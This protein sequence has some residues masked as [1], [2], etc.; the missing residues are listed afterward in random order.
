MA[1]MLDA[2]FCQEAGKRFVFGDTDCASTVDRWVRARLG[3]SPFDRY[4]RRHHDEA[5][6]RAWL[7]EPGSIA[8][9]TNRI[10]RASGIRKTADP[11]PGDIGL[12]LHEKRLCMAIFT[13]DLWI[14]RAET[15]FVAVRS[16]W[17]AWA[18]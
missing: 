5:E 12:I 6:A 7:A 15:G 4:G 13:G 14:A 10:M 2:Y 18:I 8:V 16:A 1:V 17:K 9:A 3:F 11:K